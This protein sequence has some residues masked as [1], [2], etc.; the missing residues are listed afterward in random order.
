MRLLER[1]RAAPR[2]GEG[3]SA[4]DATTAPTPTS[5]AAAELPLPSWASQD[6]F[7]TPPRKKKRGRSVDCTKKIYDYDSS[8]GMYKYLATDVSH[9]L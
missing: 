2:A 1:F 3:K 7:E 6:R 5:V 9:S 8:R 4:A